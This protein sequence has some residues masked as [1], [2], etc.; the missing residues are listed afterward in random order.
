MRIVFRTDAAWQ[1]GSGHVMRCL[2]LAESLRAGG[3]EVAFVCRAHPGHLGPQLEAL[4][5]PVRLLALDGGASADADAQPAH[6]AWVGARWETD[7]AETA[8]ALPWRPDWLIVDHYGLDW[9]W[10]LAMRASVGRILVIDDLADRRHACDLLLD[11]NLTA[12]GAARYDGLVPAGCQV[13]AGPRYA[14]LQPLYARLHQ[15]ARPRQGAVRRLLVFFGGVDRDGLTERAMRAI[16]SLSLPGVTA[17]VVVGANNPAWPDLQALAAPHA[18]L[19]LHRALPSLAPLMMQADLALGAGGATCWERLCLGLPCVVVTV[20]DNQRAVTGLLA[21]RGLVDWLGD[22]A[23]ADEPALAGALER[24]CADG[25]PAHWFPDFG[26]I[27]GQGC[28]RLCAAI[29]APSS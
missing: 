1:I 29:L 24:W 13:L 9:R 2:T 15:E 6:A 20:A 19:R 14:L 28:G 3:A 25:I 17:D 23:D 16:I 21:E 4:G 7:A 8:A 22:A 5:F 18:M 26:M 12:Q 11:Q 10:Q 27:D